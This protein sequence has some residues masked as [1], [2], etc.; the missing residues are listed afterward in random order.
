VNLTTGLYKVKITL[1]ARTSVAF[2][3]VPHVDDQPIIADIKIMQNKAEHVA[4]DIL[5]DTGT[6]LPA[7]LAPANEYDTE[8][9]A[10]QS[11][12]DN[13]DQYKADVSALALESTLE[14]I[15][16]IGWTNEDL[17]AIKTAID[18]V[19][20]DTGITLPS[21]I[22]AI[23]ED[24][25]TYP[26]RTITM[27]AAEILSSVTEEQIVAIRGNTWNISLPNLDFNPDFSDII[28]AIK[29]R[30]QDTDSASI[31]YISMNNGLLYMNG[32][33]AINNTQASI[34][35]EA[36]NL[37]IF[38]D[39]KI[40]KQLKTGRFFFGIQTISEIETYENYIGDF[41]L[42]KDVIHSTN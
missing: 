33:E 40:T 16:G 29:S 4:D 1:D 25:W 31:L 12:L 3:I 30:K 2:K 11:D 7:T 6:T 27:S 24:V 36:D 37:N 8:L 10:I 42:L 21:E 34:S 32:E 13:P 20:E 9:T 23:D 18:E 28:F 17:V 38:V 5:V 15:K 22:N 19:I 41:I 14:A 35:F 39:A 26:E